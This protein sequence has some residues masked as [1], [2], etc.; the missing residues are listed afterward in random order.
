MATRWIKPIYKIAA[1]VAMVT[2]LAGS[3]VGCGSSGSIK[4]VENA[5]SLDAVQVVAQKSY[6]SNPNAGAKSDINGH[7]F[8]A[9]SS[10]YNLYMNEEDLSVVVEDKNTGAFM[11]SSIS[12]DDEQSNYLWLA[13]MKSA[14]VITYISGNDDTKQAD[15]INDNVNKEITYTEYGFTA[16]LYWTKYQFGLTL[17]VSITDDGLLARIPDESIIENSETYYI[18]TI[19]IYPFMGTSYL[20]D[21]EGYML[22]PD[23]NG[24]LIYLNDKE[25]AYSVGFS[26]TIYGTD[27]GFKESSVETLLWDKYK[28]LTSSERVI[29]PVF[30][31]AHTDDKIAFLGIVEEGSMRATIEVHP[32]GAFVNYNRAFAKFVLRKNYTQPTSNN[33]TSGSLHITEAERSHSNLAVRFVFLSDDDANYTGMAVAYRNYLIKIGELTVAEDTSY[34]TRLDFLGTERETFLIGTRRVV[35]TSV[36]DIREIYSELEASGVQD[37]LSVYKGWQSGGLY[38][39]PIS[40]YK[41]DSGIGGTGELTDLIKDAAADGIDLYL[42]DDALR[43]NPDTHNSTFNVAKQINK[44]RYVEKTYSKVYD[45]FLYLI[46][47]R[48]DYALD[49]LVKSYTSKG[50]NNLALAGITSNIFSYTYNG[51]AFTR[52]EEGNDIIN[53][54]DEV[55]QST[56]LVLEQPNAYLWHDAK[57]FLDMPL[58][59]SSYI[60]E[61]ESIPFLSLVLKGVMPV[62]SDYVN[63]EANKT[64]FF[65]KMVETGTYPSFY[66]TKESSELLINTNSSD[67]Y[68]SQYS[69]YKDMIIEYA[70]Q[71]SAVNEKTAGAFITAHEIMSNGVRV[72]T[73][74]NGVKIYVNYS[75]SEQSVDGVTIEAMSY[76]VR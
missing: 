9:E 24:A 21:K 11:E 51:E 73:Y 47:L 48:S 67:I 54:V 49:K 15:L 43:I 56:N 74:D 22:V 16:K 13:A 64:E 23:G 27:T 3:V 68:S 8:V 57:A 17:E 28:M 53:V 25:G 20:D 66:L 14:I 76:E 71:L 38:N 44:R 42:Y 61:D 52:Y 18:G 4:E 46:P 29:A 72:V 58:Y 35:M 12:Y 26:G 5:V 62:Y 50:V 1:S 75:E 36:D 33:S 7:A 37:I 6:T 60:V 59:T 32:N 41:A 65:L 10:N 2:V 19:S 34:N 39:L 63:F 40:K 55:A 70:E 31:I 30:G 45:E 69:I